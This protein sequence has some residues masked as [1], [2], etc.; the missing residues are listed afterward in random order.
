MSRAALP[1]PTTDRL[2]PAA[3][4]IARLRINDETLRAICEWS[5]WLKPEMR[6]G[7]GEG[8][9]WFRDANLVRYLELERPLDQV[10]SPN[11]DAELLRRYREARPKRDRKAVP[12]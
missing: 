9:R 4:V 10:E 12:A 7:P 6:P 8:R 11:R 3:E 1:L 2:I 5:R